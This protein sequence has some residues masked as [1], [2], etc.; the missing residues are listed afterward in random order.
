MLILKPSWGEDK[1]H[2]KI[3]CHRKAINGGVQHSLEG[4][5]KSFC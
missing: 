5:C 1:S 3:V 2:N 4:N